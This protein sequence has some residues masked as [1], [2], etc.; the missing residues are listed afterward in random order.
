MTQNSVSF[1]CQSKQDSRCCMNFTHE[2]TCQ[3][4]TNQTIKIGRRAWPTRDHGE[5]S[6]KQLSSLHVTCSWLNFPVWGH[7]WKSRQTKALHWKSRDLA[8]AKVTQDSTNIDTIFPLLL[9]LVKESFCYIHILKE[10][11]LRHTSKYILCRKWEIFTRRQAI[12]CY[13]LRN[14]LQGCYKKSRI[15][16]KPGPRMRL[17]MLQ[18][19]CYRQ[20][21]KLQ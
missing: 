1:S 5:K 8:G 12:S 21:Q 18:P 17:C 6:Q 20:I 10:K 2:L 14:I 4:L 7:I 19:A 13:L 9:V 15:E 16:R 11:Y 3:I